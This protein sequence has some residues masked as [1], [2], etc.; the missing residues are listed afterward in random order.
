MKI[1]D[2]YEIEYNGELINT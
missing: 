2:L 1:G